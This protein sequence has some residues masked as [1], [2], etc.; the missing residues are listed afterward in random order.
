MPPPSERTTYALAP[1]VVARFV[2]LALV[3][4]AVAMFAGTAL[5]AVLELPADLL[6]G[7]LLVCLLGVGLSLIH[8]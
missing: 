5:V 3:L 7:L 1:T 2:G 8:I 6:V 4:V